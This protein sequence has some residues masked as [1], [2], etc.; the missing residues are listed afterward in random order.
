MVHKYKVRK[1]K[2]Y[3]TLQI[4]KPHNYKEQN[5]HFLA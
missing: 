3:L 5:L 4:H 2:H 1:L